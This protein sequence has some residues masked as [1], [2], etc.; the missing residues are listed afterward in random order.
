M[1]CSI[2]PGY[3]LRCVK[4]AGFI[5]RVLFV[6]FFII[7]IAVHVYGLFTHF[8]HETNTSHII[9]L[10]S[11]CLC[12]F[13]FFRNFRYG[14]LLYIVA[15]CYPFAYHAHCAWTSYSVYSKLNGIC[16]LVVLMMPLGGVY[17]GMV[18][19]IQK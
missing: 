13:T 1:V 19:S 11:Y 14:L 16:L 18:K 10:L 15:S 9:H 4:T 7:C 8:N 3:Y 12:L 2:I 17:L 6:I 5:I